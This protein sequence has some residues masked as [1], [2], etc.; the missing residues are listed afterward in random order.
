[1]AEPR[2]ASGLW[3][4]A[5]LTR[6]RLADLPA[7]VTAKG[8]ATA[9]A[10][11]VKSATLDGRARAYTGGSLD[12]T[13]PITG[14]HIA[15]VVETDS[16][17]CDIA[18]AE[19]DA[20]FKIWRLV[21]APKRGELIRLFGLEPGLVPGPQFFNLLVGVSL[22]RLDALFCF[23]NYSVGLFPRVGLYLFLYIRQGHLHIPPWQAK[24]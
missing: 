18:V 21:P 1:M 23:G 17:G 6:L 15:A 10:V 7:Y 11:I 8:D 22:Y 16:A 24:V 4:S 12:V 20:A 14:E 19:A 13:S 2:L 3:V 9:G 5:Y